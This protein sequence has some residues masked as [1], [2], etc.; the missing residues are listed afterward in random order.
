M[1]RTFV[2][3]LAA[4]FCLTAQS[5]QPSVA[6]PSPQA[7]AADWTSLGSEHKDLSFR[8]GCIVVPTAPADSNS[9][10]IVY[11]K[12]DGTEPYDF[13]AGFSLDGTTTKIINYHVRIDPGSVTV[14]F[15][16]FQRACGEDKQIYWSN[17]YQQKGYMT[18]QRTADKNA[19]WLSCSMTSQTMSA[20]N[21]ASLIVPQGSGQT[22]VL[23][24]EE[25]SLGLLAYDPDGKILNETNPVFSATEVS[26]F[27]EGL[28]QYHLDRKTLA[29]TRTGSYKEESNLENPPDITI[30]DN[31][32]GQCQKTTAPPLSS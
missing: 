29:L 6:P 9:R 17:V 31:E 22:I 8:V 7:A 1:T 23:A 18:P 26:W 5:P 28:Y 2:L 21:G 24:Y 3:L 19:V 14:T 12:N 15:F 32:S 27:Y 25:R 16:G 4:L 10:E 30:T 20:S 11:F 13:Y